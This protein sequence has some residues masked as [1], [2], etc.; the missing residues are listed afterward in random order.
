MTSGAHDPGG[1]RTLR[2]PDSVAGSAEFSACGQYRQA[3]RR[4]WLLGAGI[5]LFVGM[6]PSTA[7][8]DVDD[9]TV[10]RECDFAREWGFAA[11]IKANVMDYR[12]TYPKALLAPGVIPCSAANLPFIT[13]AAREAGRVIVAWGALPKVLQCHADAVAAALRASGVP[14]YCL[15]RT[16]SGAPRH[17]LYLPKTATPEHWP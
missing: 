17:P 2:L 5:V 7:R 11:Y 4:S 1:R 8:G 3:L 9:P 16:A 12:A 14:M 6:N 15:G 13:S 10:R